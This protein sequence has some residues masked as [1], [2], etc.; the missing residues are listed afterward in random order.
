MPKLGFND[1]NDGKNYKTKVGGSKIGVDIFGTKGGTL[2][3]FV[4]PVGDPNTVLIMSAHHVLFY[5]EFKGAAPG[6]D[7]GIGV[8]QPDY[9]GSLCCVCNE[10]AKNL[11]GDKEL[12]CAFARLKPD[13]KFAPKIRR[14]KKSDGSVEL[15]GFLK[16]VDFAVQGNPVWKVGMKS[17]LTRGTISEIHPMVPL[18]IHASAPF[19]YFIDNGD[20]GSVLVDAVTE[21]V[22]GLLHSG[23]ADGPTVIAFASHMSEIVHK[24]GVDVLATNVGENF[25]VMGWDDEERIGVAGP[26]TPDDVFAAVADRLR[27]TEA[28]TE[29]LNLFGRHRNEIAELINNRKTVT[30][31]WHRSQGPAYLAALMRS[32]REPAYHIPESLNGVTRQELA[33]RLREAFTRYGSDALRATWPLMR[34]RSTGSGSNRPTWSR[35]SRPGSAAAL[36]PWWSEE[37]R[38]RHPKCSRAFRDASVVVSRLAD[39]GGGDSAPTVRTQHRSG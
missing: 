35:V 25:E 23:P 6:T 24:F 22:V 20:S 2:G 38:M 12:D 1:E 32:V 15:N 31:A 5:R 14:I 13:V 39:L 8:G 29:L 33:D 21:R 10:I 7:V 16:G 3:C 19:P 11:A 30:V 9:S 37:V 34:T 26:P 18:E 36:L 27:M 4:S 28:G 17:G